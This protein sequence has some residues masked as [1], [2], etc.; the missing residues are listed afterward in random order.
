MNWLESFSR[1]KHPANEIHRCES[2][3]SDPIYVARVQGAHGIKGAAH[4]IKGAV[5]GSKGGRPRLDLT[6]EQRRER[7][8]QQQEAWRRRNG[9]PP[10]EVR[11]PGKRR[12]HWV[13]EYVDIWGKPPWEPL[14]P[15]EFA[16]REPLWNAKVAGQQRSEALEQARR[17]ACKSGASLQ[18]DWEDLRFARARVRGERWSRCSAAIRS[19]MDRRRSR[20]VL[21]A[22]GPV[23]GDPRLVRS[24]REAVAPLS[25]VG[26]NQP[27]P[28]GSGRKFKKCCGT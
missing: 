7:R 11:P 1:K 2:E 8:R 12:K 21:E 10:K 3:S 9:I 26:R 17:L 19:A 23:P 27:C 18:R 5:H 24:S 28:C 15:E 25:N 20:P 6:D 13:Q 16:E 14:T 4:G 22:P